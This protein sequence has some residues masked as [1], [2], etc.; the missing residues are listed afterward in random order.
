LSGTVRTA[1]KTVSRYSTLAF[2]FVTDDC[3]T[4]VSAEADFYYLLVFLPG[5]QCNFIPVFFVILN[6]YWLFENVLNFETKTSDIDLSSEETSQHKRSGMARVDDGSHSFTCTPTR[7]STND[8]N[9][10]CLPVEYRRSYLF[11]QSRL[12][13][14]W[15]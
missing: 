13:G 8:I 2:Y 5:C 9:H 4:T 10:T 7:L 1:V 14:Q 15:M 6:I 12:T 3:G 11:K